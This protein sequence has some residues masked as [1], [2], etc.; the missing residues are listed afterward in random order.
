MFQPV[1][2]IKTGTDV[3]IRRISRLR[4]AIGST[5][6]P[7]LFKAIRSRLQKALFEL[8]LETTRTLDD[9]IRDILEQIGNN[10]ELLRGSEAKILAQ[11]G[12]FLERLRVVVDEVMVEMAVIGNAAAKVKAEAEALGGSI[13]L[14]EESRE[15]LYTAD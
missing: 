3:T 12:D 11:N 14:Q 9:H 5:R 4:R 6:D 15:A 7:V 8:A 1:V 13:L 10:I 2:D